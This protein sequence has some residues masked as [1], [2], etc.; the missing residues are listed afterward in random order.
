L[1]ALGLRSLELLVKLL[2]LP[3]QEVYLLDL[4][5]Y[6]SCTL[7]LNFEQLSLVLLLGLDELKPSKF[8]LTFFLHLRLFEVAHALDHSAQVV[9]LFRIGHFE[10]LNLLFVELSLLFKAPELLLVLFEHLVLSFAQI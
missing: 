9:P 2:D 10:L 4:R 6:L 3:R 5:V 1:H 8:S 7:L